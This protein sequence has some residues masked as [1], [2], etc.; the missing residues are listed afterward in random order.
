MRAHDFTSDPLWLKLLAGALLAIE[1]A[2]SAAASYAGEPTRRQLG[3]DPYGNNVAYEFSVMD[4]GMHIRDIL[5]TS[6]LSQLNVGNIPKILVTT[7]GK[8]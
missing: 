6:L 2:N 4:F 5:F 8:Q 7:P 3:R 1:T